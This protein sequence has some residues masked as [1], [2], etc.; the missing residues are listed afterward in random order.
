VTEI[1]RIERAVHSAEYQTYAAMVGTA[2]GAALL[3]PAGV[4]CDE[5]M[6]NAMQLQR[7]LAEI[8]GRG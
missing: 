4:E 6:A 8:A 5:A 3:M 2:I 7:K 1:E